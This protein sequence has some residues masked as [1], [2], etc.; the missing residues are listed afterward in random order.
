MQISNF[1]LFPISVPYLHDERSSRVHRGGVTA[2]AIR[3]STDD[4]HV[5]W[6]EACVGADAASI[7]A[8]AES[9]RPFLIGRSP[10]QSEAIVPAARTTHLVARSLL[11]FVVSRQNG[12]TALEIAKR[13]GHDAVVAKLMTC[14]HG[15]I[16]KLMK[17]KL[18]M[19]EQTVD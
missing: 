12:L 3:L 2:I 7:L 1:E 11:E 18:K 15:D 16:A 10:W 14:A 13:F 9:A 17:A 4:G 8:A 19:E 6:G 5:G